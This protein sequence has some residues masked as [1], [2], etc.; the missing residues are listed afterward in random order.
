M[1]LCGL[2][3]TQEADEPPDEVAAAV[4]EGGLGQGHFLHAVA[5]CGAL[6]LVP[7]TGGLLRPLLQRQGAACPA[8]RDV[9]VRRCGPTAVSHALLSDLTQTQSTRRLTYAGEKPA[10]LGNIPP[11][12]VRHPT[13]P[14]S[15]A[16][17]GERST[18]SVCVLELSPLQKLI[19]QIRIYRLVN[20]GTSL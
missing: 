16:Q 19:N 15:A 14:D 3:F 12:A 11:P 6:V 18:C 9:R 20:Q 17:P 13:R 1:V 5:R 7:G 4:A 8:V 10:S 2:T